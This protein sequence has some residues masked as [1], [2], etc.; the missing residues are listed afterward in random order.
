MEF[1]EALQR[2]AALCS[3]QERNTQY[4][5]RKLSEWEISSV[6]AEKIIRK[7]KEDKFL[8]DRRYASSFVKDKFRFNRWGRIKIGYALRQKGI[9]EEAIGEALAQIDE[10]DYFQTCRELIRQKSASL[11]ETNPYTRKA[12]LVRFASQRGFES[13]LVYRILQTEE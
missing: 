10:E 9:P 7:L 5:A 13:E 1:K 11:K 4:I 6:D 8:D 3:N 12:K 2:T